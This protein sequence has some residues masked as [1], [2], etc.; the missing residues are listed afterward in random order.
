MSEKK[1][2][3]CNKSMKERKFREEEG[4]EY[5]TKAST[6][7]QVFSLQSFLPA[8]VNPPYAVNLAD[9]SGWGQLGP[10]ASALTQTCIN[11]SMVGYIMGDEKTY[12]EKIYGGYVKKD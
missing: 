12:Y 7:G 4:V 8:H 11:A 2:S 10:T 1:F 3:T 6:S 9:K 5:M